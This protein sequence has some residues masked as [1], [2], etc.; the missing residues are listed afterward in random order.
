MFSPPKDIPVFPREPNSTTPHPGGDPHL[1]STH[2]TTYY[3]IHATDGDIGHV[4]DFIV[5]DET[6][7]ISD[8]V[9]DT[10]NWLPGR[11]VLVAPQSITAVS[12]EDAK[13]LLNLSR[14]AV[15]QSPV[16][17]PHK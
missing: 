4:D 9:V 10:R 3:R 11:R 14:D 5:D 15:R 13:V 6:W 12:W 16:F 8:L 7:C 2:V 17:D 1:R